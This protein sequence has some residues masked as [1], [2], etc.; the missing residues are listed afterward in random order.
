MS[1]TTPLLI[2]LYKNKILFKYYSS[3]EKTSTELPKIFKKIDRDYNIIE[4]Y[5][6]KGPGSFMAI[7]I[8]YIFLKSY[9]IVKNILLKA[10]DGFY[11][12]N[13]MPIKAIGKM[14][15]IKKGDNIIL[16]LAPQDKLT[17][18][19]LPDILRNE[20]FSVNCAPLYI[21]PAV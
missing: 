18:F 4:L 8:S 6:A 14:C 19:M 16:D 15:F 3:I 9:A 10:I 17:E 7:K 2:G 21:L 5:Y 1:L 12:N 13:N 20:D 11:F